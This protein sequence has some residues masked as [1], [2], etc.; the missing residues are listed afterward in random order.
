MHDWS[1]SISRIFKVVDPYY[2]FI[3]NYCSHSI[4]IFVFRLKV[5]LDHR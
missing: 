5:D 3:Y 1:Q 2:A 4:K